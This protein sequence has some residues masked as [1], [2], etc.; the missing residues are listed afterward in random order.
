MERVLS[1]V[2][3]SARRTSTVFRKVTLPSWLSDEHP[4]QKRGENCT[5][6]NVLFSLPCWVLWFPPESLWSARTSCSII[7]VQFKCITH[8][9]TPIKRV[10][11]IDLLLAR[12]GLG[13]LYVYAGEILVLRGGEMWSKFWTK[14][15]DFWVMC[16][17]TLLINSRS[18]LLIVARIFVFSR[19]VNTRT[20]KINCLKNV[21]I[22]SAMQRRDGWKIC[23]TQIVWLWSINTFLEYG[24]F[25]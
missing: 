9:K 17:R 8:N 21:Q 6:D 20:G 19:W 18:L 13:E 7:S 16:V 5:R 22:I 25:H 23:S 2:L 1:P 14:G 4:F 24:K 15:K 11:N 3:A 12:R 10:E